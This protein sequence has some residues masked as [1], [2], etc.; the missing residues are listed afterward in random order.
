MKTRTLKI[1]I[2][3]REKQRKRMRAIVSGEFRPSKGEPKVWFTSIESVAQILS[4]KNLLLL[5]MIA[6]AQPASI[7]ELAE[8]AGRKKGNLSRTLRT[9]AQYGIVELEKKNN[10]VTPKVKF[11]SFDV[12]LAA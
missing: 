8:L 6:R 12:K 7:S 2:A 10:R 9:M 11:T 5:E 4:S 1:G 3:S